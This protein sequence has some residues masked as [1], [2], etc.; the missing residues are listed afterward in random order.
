[1]FLHTIM[2]QSGGGHLGAHD[3]SSYQCQTVLSQLAIKDMQV[4]DK[5][6]TSGGDDMHVR[7]TAAGGV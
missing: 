4:Q 7:D 3:M 5:D 2:E 6:C 1:M